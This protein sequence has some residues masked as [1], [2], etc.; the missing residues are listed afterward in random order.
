M[1]VLNLGQ[2]F[3]HFLCLL[4]VTLK[5][6]GPF[7]LVSMPGEVKDSMWG[8]GKTCCGLGNSR[9][10]HLE[11]NHQSCWDLGPVSVPLLGS[12]DLYQSRCWGP[13]TCISPVAGVPRPVSVPLLGSPDLYQS[14][15]WGPQ[16]CISPVA[17]VPRPV[18]VPLLGSPDLYQSCC[19]GP[20]TCISPVAGVPRPVS[21]PSLGPMLH[22]P[23]SVSN[24]RTCKKIPVNCVMYFDVA[25]TWSVTRISHVVNGSR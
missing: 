9:R 22:V 6:V 4:E 23:F 8:S 1:D 18:S 24:S 10:G 12:P 11:I 2:C 14:R 25:G 3:P 7:Y 21:V 13:Q 5:A 20:Q 16:T 17:G 19:W 15:C